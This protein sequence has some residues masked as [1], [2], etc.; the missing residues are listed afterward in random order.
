LSP[1]FNKQILI[2]YTN[3]ESGDSATETEDTDP[4]HR[5]LTGLATNIQLNENSMTDTD[6]DHTL[7]AI[8]EHQC[9][10]TL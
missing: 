7:N 8:L 3:T 4:L 5:A 9:C 6:W 2:L 1:P 10:I